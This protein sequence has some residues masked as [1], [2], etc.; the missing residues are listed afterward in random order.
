MNPIVGTDKQVWPDAFLGGLPEAE[1]QV[2]GGEGEP[3][4]GNAGIDL[5]KAF[6]YVFEDG[7]FG[8]VPT[9]P[10]DDPA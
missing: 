5:L 9:V 8:A 2:L 4:D 10:D 6:E 3:D 1:E 7:C